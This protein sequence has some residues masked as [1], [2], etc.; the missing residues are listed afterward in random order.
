MSDQLE[1]EAGEEHPLQATTNALPPPLVLSNLDPIVT[2]LEKKRSSEVIWPSTPLFSSS[3]PLAGNRKRGDET[4]LLTP[5]TSVSESGYQGEFFGGAKRKLSSSSL[6]TNSFVSK[7]SPL[8]LE[9]WR[10]PDSPPISRRRKHPSPLVPVPRAWSGLILAPLGDL[11][12]IE[13]GSLDDDEK[14]SRSEM[15]ELKRRLESTLRENEQL[16]AENSKLKSFLPPARQLPSTDHGKWSSSKSPN[17]MRDD[18]GGFG[19]EDDPQSEKVLQNE[20]RAGDDPEVAR[21]KMAMRQLMSV[22]TL[23]KAVNETVSEDKIVLKKATSE[24]EVHKA[25]LSRALER[26]RE[27]EQELEALKAEKG[28]Y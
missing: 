28:A 22:A 21:T 11:P 17:H 1:S 23:L 7:K 8:S 15:N 4:L 16:K 13:D 5:R 24:V 9:E 27:L 25:Q 19:G 6:R 12:Q 26:I 20:S 18:Y 2:S 14:L 10:R 3:T